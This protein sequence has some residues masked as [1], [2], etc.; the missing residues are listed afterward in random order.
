MGIRQKRL[1][2]DKIRILMIAPTPFFADRGCHVRIYEEARALQGHGCEVVL[3]TYHIGRDM[4]GI[5]TERI[6]NIPWYKKLEAGPSW[7]KPFLDVLLLIKSFQTIRRFK[8]HV[9]HAHLHEGAFIGRFLSRRLSIPLLFDYQ[10]SMTAEMADHEFM[11]KGGIFFNAL[12]RL[13][14]WI[15]IGADVIVT[16]SGGSAANL[17]SDFNIPVEK[18]RTVIDGVDTDIF[19]PGYDT[20]DLKKRLGISEDRKVIIYLGLLN[21]YQ[22]VDL[23]LDAACDVVKRDPKAHFLIM[24]YPD[25]E[26][27]T[28]M[29]GRMGIAGNVT[30]TGRIDYGEAPKS[31]CL[32]DIAVSAKLSKTEAN[33]KIFNYMAA[34]LP[35]VCFDT[36]VNREILD[37]LGIYAEFGSKE[38]LA[39]AMIKALSE[40]ERVAN[41][42]M[43]V[44]KRAVEELSWMRAREKILA[45]YRK[46]NTR[47]P[48]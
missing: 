29:A 38:S 19:R 23:L 9:I 32:G 35:T 45:I 42:K 36:P 26:K 34:G 27:Y 44:R 30:F 3:C 24:G 21:E 6:L 43:L 10:G 33:G 8:P 39:A 28:E 22:G 12:R 20:G 25:V 17:L 47:L 11:T 5:R 4:E 37:D 1:M 2:K 40:P 46:I 16:S 48:A 31:L 41:L 7:Q 18:I 14:R 13:E 15:D